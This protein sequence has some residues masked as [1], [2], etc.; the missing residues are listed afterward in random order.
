MLAFFP[1]PDPMNF[2]IDIDGWPKDTDW[3]DLAERAHEA[4]EHV[5]PV[6]A[7]PRLTASILFTVD[8]EVH[9]LNREWRTKDKPTNV[10]SF[11]ML[12]REELMALAQDG[13]PEML[14][15]IALAFETCQREAQEKGATLADHTAHLLIHG[16]L[17][18]AGHDHV[19]SDQQAEAMENLEI[20]A[21]AK[22]GISDPYGDRDK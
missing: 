1:R 20:E 11:P 2:D 22:M 9:T 15:D 18:L 5:E 6:L 13:G 17:H 21:L 19:D 12:T 14:G 16:M 10:L 8:E 3:A 4:V 7:N